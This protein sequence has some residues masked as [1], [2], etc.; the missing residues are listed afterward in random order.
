MR[1]LKGYKLLF[2]VEISGILFQTGDKS[3]L[4]MF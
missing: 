4:D 2:A 3:E 1:I